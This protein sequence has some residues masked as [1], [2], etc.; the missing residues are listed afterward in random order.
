MNCPVC[1][2]PSTV[3]V[4]L[5]T[6]AVVHSSCYDELCAAWV[7]AGQQAATRR[8]DV[9]AAL[10]ALRRRQTYYGRVSGALFGGEAEATIRGRLIAAEYAAGQADRQR[11][12]TTS[13]ALPIF[14]V[15]IGYPPDWLLRTAAV[16]ERDGV[17]VRCGST[18]GLDTHHTKPLSKGG[19]NQLANLE[20][21][22]RECHSAAH[23]GRSLKYEGGVDRPPAIAG[24]V[25]VLARAI[26][27]G[28]DVEF[29]YQKPQD[30][31]P[32]KR[33]LSPSGLSEVAHQRDGGSTLCVE[34][35]CHV[36]QSG[37]VFA[38]KRMWGVK[39]LEP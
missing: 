38:L 5:A 23:A 15:L 27:M 7:A 32:L 39:L 17:C 30:L 2:S 26:Q 35:F 29:M 14:D 28:L 21:L 36:R 12:L 19:T 6:G 11:E 13:H 4:S 16:Y 1:E 20:L 25:Q 24:R 10:S 8:A 3:G 37:R 31:L 18:S 34:G 22:C 33:R 9:A